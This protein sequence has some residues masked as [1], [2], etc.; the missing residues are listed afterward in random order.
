MGSCQESGFISGG[1]ITPANYIDTKELESVLKEILSAV[2]GRRCFAD[3]G[4]ASKD[5]RT[6]LREYGLRKH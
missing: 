3:K 4:Y 2:T 1:H 5:N 6:M